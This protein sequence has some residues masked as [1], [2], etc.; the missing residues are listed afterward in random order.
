MKFFLSLLSLLTANLLF[1]GIITSSTNGNWSSTSSWV[2]G[3]VPG[4]NDT[5]TIESGHSITLDG[6]YTIAR[7]VLNNMA[8]IASATDAELNISSGNTLTVTGNVTLNTTI[9]GAST[10]STSINIEGTLSVG[11]NLTLS[12]TLLT[13]A[14][15]NAVTIGSGTNAGTM[16]VTGDISLSNALLSA[17]GVSNQITLG[18]GTMDVDGSISMSAGAISLSTT[19]FIE[20]NDD[21]SFDSKSKTF[22]YGGN[23]IDCNDEGSITVVDANSNT[24]YEFWWD[25]TSA[26]TIETDNITYNHLYVKNTSA[27][28]DI[29]TSLTNTIV[30]GKLYI[31]NGAKLHLDAA[32]KNLDALSGSSDKINI[33]SGGTL[34]LSPSAYADGVPPNG[35]LTS[36][37]A[38]YIE[39]YHPTQGLSEDIIQEAVDYPIVKLSGPGTKSLGSSSLDIDDTSPRVGRIWLAEGVFS[40]DSGKEISLNS[41]Y[42]TKV[43]QLDSATTMRIDGNFTT[44]DTYWSVDRDNTVNYYG[45]AT[46]TLY[47]LTSDGST[48]EPYG[49][50]KLE[51]TSGS[52]INRDL[53]ASDTIHVANRLEIGT[54]IELVLNQS[55]YVKMLSNVTFTAYID[56]IA[57]TGAITYS[58]SPRGRF[59][60]QKYLPLPYVA[61]RDLSSPIQGTT[62]ASWK[63]K[64]LNMYGFSGSN[65]PG[66]VRNSVHHYDETVLDELNVGFTDATSINDAVAS[67]DG[68]EFDRSVWRVLYGN[69]SDTTFAI[70]LEDT[71][72]IYTGDQTF[73]LKFNYSNYDANS[74]T[75]HDGWNH[76]GNPYAAPINWNDIYNDAAN[77][78]LK[79]NGYI[80]STA[81]I[82]GQVDRYWQDPGSPGY[83]GFY[84]AATETSYIH[85]SIIPAYQGFWVKAYHSSSSS[86]TYTLTIKES[87]K[88]RQ[89]SSAYYKSSNRKKARDISEVGLKVRLES[90]NRKDFLWLMDFPKAKPE[91]D[92]NFDVPRF[93][94]I[95]SRSFAVDVLED[96]TWLNLW[97]NALD[98]N[99]TE[100]IEMPLGIKSNSAGEHH[101]TFENMAALTKN[102]CLTLKRKSTG[103]VFFISEGKRIPVDLTD[104]ISTDYVLVFGGDYATEFEVKDPVCAGDQGLVSINTNEMFYS[105]NWQLSKAGMVMDKF[106]VLQDEVN[107]QLTAGNYKLTNLSG[108]LACGIK[109]LD[110]EVVDGA[111][112]DARFFWNA[113][114]TVAQG[115][116]I[117]LA[118]RDRGNEYYI[119]KVDGK[120][121][122]VKDLLVSFENTGAKPL[123]LETNRENCVKT[124]R[125][126][127]YVVK[128]TTSLSDHANL[129][130]LEIKNGKIQLLDMAKQVQI[131]TFEGKLIE[132]LPHTSAI[133]LIQGPHIYCIDEKC[134]KIMFTPNNP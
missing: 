92:I 67:F 65:V 95:G 54:E 31:D 96:T 57:S 79:T 111:E 55:S 121:S 17:L 73:K 78:T 53:P 81:Y 5:V 51:R 4:V 50:L 134:L 89:D 98:I 100:E 40:V 16:N 120:T 88:Y 122:F 25:G 46:Q 23:S 129:Q 133:N 118:P 90:G 94:A 82:L 101:L 48:W 58:G 99:T 24:S 128:S 3:V 109:S 49:I 64:G 14:G 87:H 43:I 80:T 52:S 34:K 60:I 130:G 110:F 27:D 37:A 105:S 13:I 20:S 30:E 61:Y 76:V 113:G 1:A 114:D 72:R 39:F 75:D 19:N 93:G 107:L 7:L 11:G 77:A 42:G 56:E 29:E 9:S 63:N 74:R 33:L 119:W 44:L 18:N 112:V 38:G 41:S 47:E 26:Q 70:T 21:G 36:N 103:E 132:T 86:E 62:L 2:G 69:N 45:N 104:G 116:V 83:Y 125:D 131:F 91:K 28:V 108:N 66:A 10:G 97:V 126:T 8:D 102:H 115:Q 85:D 59:G 35:V 15:T 127:I 71:G 117:T 22:K 84:N 68:S 32:G 6:S 12:S 106:A 124:E 123:Q